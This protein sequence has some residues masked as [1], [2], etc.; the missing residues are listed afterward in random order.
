MYNYEGSDEWHKEKSLHSEEECNKLEKQRR[1]D[2]YT[3]SDHIIRVVHK[4]D[5]V[6]QTHYRTVFAKNDPI[7]ID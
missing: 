7:V 5:P 6:D 3:R 4:G 1:Q 2:S